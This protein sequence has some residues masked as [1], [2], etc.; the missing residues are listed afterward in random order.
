VSTAAPPEASPDL[1]RLMKTARPVLPVVLVVLVLLV[2]WL[3][4]GLYWIR[5]FGLVLMLALVVS[6]LNL[7]L[8]Y[9][10]ELALGQVA[11][12]AVGAYVSGYVAIHV[13]ADIF[14]NLLVAAMAALVIGVVSGI[15]GLRLGGWSLAMTSFFLVLLV[16]DIVTI[17]QRWTGGQIGLFDIPPLTLFGQQ[18]SAKGYYLCIAV[19]AVLWFLVMRNLVTSRHGPAFLVLRQSPVLASSLGISPQRM[20]LTAYALGAVPAGLAG[21]LFASLDHFITPQSPGPFDFSQSIAVLAAAVLGGLTSVY[22][23]L[24]GALVLQLGPM[25]FTSFQKYSDVVY[26]AF[27]IV[28]GV[29]LSQGATGLL[30]RLLRR[31][32]PARAAG[33][34]AGE[35]TPLDVR[36]P[37]E[38]LQVTGA[39]K[40]FGGLHALADVTLAAEPGQVTAVIGPNGSGKTTLL[41]LIS[42]FYRLTAGS[43]T[44]G[45]TAPSGAHHV[46]RAGVARTFQTPLIPRDLT[47]AEAVATGRYQRD[48]RSMPATIIRSPGYRRTRAADHKAV[49]HA[50]AVTGLRHLADQNAAAQPVGIRRLIEVARALAAEPGIIL[51]D[52]VASGLDDDEVEQLAALIGELRAAGATVVL[53]EHNFALVLKVSD[54]IHVLANGALVA[55]GAPDAIASHPAILR[56]YLGITEDALEPELAQVQGR[57]P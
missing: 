38:A 30:R 13:S 5:E 29:L 45:G 35:R 32:T 16:P 24:L 51:F 12:Y 49:E 1:T 11:F 53:V 52:E 48:Y 56:E 34:T 18:L 36:L 17:L 20:K 54:L 27:L 50:L 26:G 6:G 23:A 14:L 41:N 7:S 9:A 46:A 31:L 19:V 42:G 3:G 25:R 40:S 28:F 39:S 44:V 37:G 47:V 10:G 8:G 2:P 22:G 33:R 4:L 21:A 57:E 55:S 15:P 43:I